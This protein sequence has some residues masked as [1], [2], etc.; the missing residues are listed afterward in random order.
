MGKY[1]LLIA[2]S[3]YRDERLNGLT[4][5]SAD[6]YS[7]K[8]V[9]DDQGIGAFSDVKVVSNADLVRTQREIK[10][11]LD[12]RAADDL[13]LIYFTGHGLVD[14]DGKLWL[15]MA[16]SS[17]DPDAAEIGSYEAAKLTRALD[18][19]AATQQLLILDC[20]HSGAIDANLAGGVAKAKSGAARPAISRNTFGQKTVGRYV[21]ASS[22]A[23]QLSY[24][25]SSRS[26]FTKAL[27]E[28]IRTGAA[29]P[30]CDVI[31]LG[32]I[33]NYIAQQLKMVKA[34]MT[35]FVVPE[36]REAQRLVICKNPNPLKSIPESIVKALNDDSDVER[37]L[38]AITRIYSF[39]QTEQLSGS[40]PKIAAVLDKRL[41]VEEHVT[42]HS[43]L[44]R[45]RE[46]VTAAR[47]QAGQSTDKSHLTSLVPGET[48]R[49]PS[50]SIFD[51][52]MRPSTT[53]AIFAIAALLTG[54]PLY[55]FGV[56]IAAYYGA[57][58]GVAKG[59]LAIPVSLLGLILAA[60]VSGI[61]SIRLI[62]L[63]SFAWF[64][65]LFAFA[66]LWTLAQSLNVS[67]PLGGGFVLFVFPMAYLVPLAVI[68]VFHTEFMRLRL[69]AT[70]YLAGLTTFFLFA[71]AIY[72]L[73]ADNFSGEV[74]IVMINLLVFVY[75]GLCMQYVSSRRRKASSPDGS[76][77]V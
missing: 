59:I 50:N 3:D 34:P 43:E 61:R 30:E 2:N 72:L 73:N 28:G 40:Q 67:T 63:V 33:A 15:A 44:T 47:I 66:V 8:A 69:F 20:C 41:Q 10:S 68:S 36:K 13:A 29:A 27:V 1:A 7:L 52:L 64:I 38:G 19:C 16:E 23:T 24:E 49:T 46:K 77:A 75:T 48:M 60:L 65:G 62:G 32:D 31:T 74:M 9:L 18:R 56:R 12:E 4:A 22:S 54:L 37:R 14:S 42:V 45:L 25:I 26:Q 53:I 39:L 58:I 6:I 35:P 21:L 51:D 71:V 76:S 70:V 5:P 57:E 17:P 11:F 55:L